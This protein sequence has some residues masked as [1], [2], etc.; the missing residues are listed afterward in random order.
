MSLAITKPS[1]KCIENEMSV[2]IYIYIYVE[3]SY[4][5]RGQGGSTI[6]FTRHP[7]FLSVAVVLIPGK[8]V[9]SFS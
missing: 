6:F 3:F 5:P 9:G 4:R 8:V 1:E 7:K 2:Y